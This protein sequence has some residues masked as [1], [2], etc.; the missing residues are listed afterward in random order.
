M[1]ESS[2]TTLRTVS[3]LSEKIRHLVDSFE[4]PDQIADPKSWRPF[5][6]FCLALHSELMVRR[7]PIRQERN[8]ED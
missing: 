2:G 6:D 1:G 5:L 3:E 8:I 7:G 4:A